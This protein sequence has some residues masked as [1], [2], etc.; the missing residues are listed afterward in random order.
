MSGLPPKW[1][2]NGNSVLQ[3]VSASL[4]TWIQLYIYN[5]KVPICLHN[6][7]QTHSVCGHASSK[8]I[9]KKE[10]PYS[11]LSC[12]RQFSNTSNPR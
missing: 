3:S 12:V 5:V 2:K 9:R 1:S 10:M 4:T 8:L 6:L 7:A 11:E